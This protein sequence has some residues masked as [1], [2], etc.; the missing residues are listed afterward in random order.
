MIRKSTFGKNLCDALGL[1]PSDVFSIKLESAF[2]EVDT[3]TI[4]Q[5]ANADRYSELGKVF[6]KYKI[7][8]IEEV[9]IPNAI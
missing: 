1:D 9:K 2:G 4:G 8:P 5:Y 3:L 7:V 6:K